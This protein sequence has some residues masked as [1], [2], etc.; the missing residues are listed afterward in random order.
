MSAITKSNVNLFVSLHFK[1]L[2]VFH[3]SAIAKRQTANQ[4]VCVSESVPGVAW[5]RHS[6]LHSAVCQPFPPPPHTLFIPPPS[7]LCLFS[8]S[9]SFHRRAAAPS[10]RIRHGEPTA[11]QR[12]SVNSVR[13]RCHKFWGPCSVGF[14]ICTAMLFKGRFEL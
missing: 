6:E 11:G 14:Y 2:R 9:R 1:V 10:S 3:K 12:S 7:P 13:M 4:L 8:A 5:R